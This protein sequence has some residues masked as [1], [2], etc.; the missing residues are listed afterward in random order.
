MA[1]PP[2]NKTETAAQKDNASGEVIY[3]AGVFPISDRP[4]VLS[5]FVSPSPQIVDLNSNTFTRYLEKKL[6]IKFKFVV[7]PQ[8]AS[9]E[10][11]QI[12]LAGKDYPE[13]FLSAD[14]TQAEQ[15]KFGQQGILRPLNELI[16]K[17][18]DEIKK[19]FVKKP[20]LRKAITAPDGNI[21]AL[22]SVNDCLHCWYAQKL[23]INQTWLN[24][25]NLKMPRTTDEFYQVLKAFKTKDPNGN[26]KQDEIPLTGAY[27]SWHTQITGFLMSAFIYNNDQDYFFMRQGKVGLAAAKP[28]WKKG[29]EYMHKLYSEGLIDP[30]S[31]TQNEDGLSQLGN[32]DGDNVIGSATMGHVGMVFNTKRGETRH[33]EYSTVTPLIGPDG[34]QV[35]GY[36]NTIGNGQFAITNKATETKAAAAMRMADYLY[37]E[38]AAI[39]NEWGPENLW[40]RK[41]QPGEKDEHGRVAKYFLKPEVWEHR[42]QNESWA[43]LGILFRDRD[44][45]ESWAV[46][47]D[48]Y[49]DD[50]YEHRLYVETVKNYQGKEPKQLFP[51]DIFIGLDDVN[52]AAQLRVQ[53]ND[54]IE[55]NMVQ[56]ITGD[57]DI[58]KEWNAYINGF[59]GLR[60]NR[61]L[62]IYQKAY[63]DFYKK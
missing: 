55:S 58:D 52:E 26:G 21:Y 42:A 56:F 51:L 29:L 22:P 54:Y 14:F 5:M 8:S 45:R 4:V 1:H 46:P 12:L 35:A 62:E 61:Y 17:Y 3:P 32:K 24:K 41:T 23:W 7:V 6:N 31:F 63:D 50:G 60:S 47:Q 18:G 19:A 15:L 37:S 43:Q 44:L 33:K 11:N 30:S 20:E 34:Y 25:L 10:R 49:A 53:I 9:N 59:R 38:E 48:P 57:K 28:E 39:Q 13:V 16:D 40:W 27:K 36:F 2:F